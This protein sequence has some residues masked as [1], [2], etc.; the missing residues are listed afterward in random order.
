MK[1][2]IQSQKNDAANVVASSN[3]TKRKRV[4]L[5]E[6][7]GMTR[8]IL[9][10]L[11]RS[12]GL[13]VDFASN[14]S[15]ALNRLRQHPD[16]ILMELNLLGI[17]G[18]EFIREARG[19]SQFGKKP[20]YIFTCA[21]FMS[22]AARKVVTGEG[23][24]LFDKLSVLPEKVVIQIAADLMGVKLSEE[25]HEAISSDKKGFQTSLK[26]R[27]DLKK[28]LTEIHEASQVLAKSA[29]P[30]EWLVNCGELRRKV[31]GLLSFAAVARMSN[32]ARQAQ[33]LETYLNQLCNEPKLLNKS[34]L[35]TV[36][37]SVEMLDVLSRCPAEEGGEIT[38]YSAVIVDQAPASCTALND[39]FHDAGF[40]PMSFSEPDEA[41][42]HLSTHPAHLL[43]LNVRV[44]ELH[45]LDPNKIRAIP[46]HSTTP[47][48][49]V[50]SP[51]DL[52][53]PP[54][55]LPI[56]AARMDVNPVALTDLVLKALSVVQ[57]RPATSAAP[58]HTAAPASAAKKPAAEKPS[59][60]ASSPEDERKSILFVEDDPVMQ[61]V[62]KTRLEREGFRIESAED[63]LIALEMLPTV[64][65]DLVVLDLML[66]KLHG[67]E[68]LKFIRADVNLKATPVIV[69][70]NVYMEGMAVKAIKS[71][72]NMGMLKTQCTPGKLIS[73]ARE[74]LGTVPASEAP[75]LST[76]ESK[77]QAAAQ[78]VRTGDTTHEGTRLDLLK[79]APQLIAQ[80]RQDCLNFVRTSGSEV[81]QD[82]L[83]SLYRNVRFLGAR[84]GLSGFANVATAASALEALLFEI[85]FNYSPATPSA[86]QSIAQ[87]VDCLGRMFQNPSALRTSTRQKPKVLVVDDDA[88]CTTA[89]VAALKR[90]SFEAFGVQDPKFA[91]SMMQT[92]RF[93]LV[94]LDLN[95]PGMN[96]FQVCEELRKLPDYRTTPVI[97]VT[98]SGEFQDRARGI[99]AGG[100]DLITKPVSPLEL[101]LKST[102][103]LLDP[104][105]Q[106]TPPIPAVADAPAVASADSSASIQVETAVEDSGLAMAESSPEAN[107]HADIL[108]EQ[109]L[110]SRMPV[111]ASGDPDSQN[112][113]SE[114][115][116]A[117]EA[118]A[119]PTLDG[120]D[121]I[122][123]E[124]RQ[125]TEEQHEG[126][127]ETEAQPRAEGDL[128]FA[129]IPDIFQKAPSQPLPAPEA[130][131]Q[132][133]LSVPAA[134][135][136]GEEVS[137]EPPS[138]GE[139]PGFEETTDNDSE[140]AQ[141]PPPLLY[142]AAINPQEE[143]EKYKK[144]RA[145]LTARLYDA[146][147]QLDHTRSR[148]NRR[149]EAIKQLQKQL[150][151]LTAAKQELEKQSVEK[152]RIAEHSQE[153]N[154]QVRQATAEMAKR[155]KE[156]EDELSQNKAALEEAKAE[157]AKQSAERARLEEDL[158]QHLAAAASTAQRVEAT[159]RETQDR[160]ARLERDVADLRQSREELNNKF[161]QELKA[162]AES[163]KRVKELESELNQSHSALEQ[164]KAEFAKQ[165][166]ERTR[167]EQE[168]RQ[169]LAATTSATQQIEAAQNESQ[170]RCRQLEQD[171]A[172]LRQAREELTTQHA[173]ERQ[174]ATDTN[175][176]I[177]ELENELNQ[178]KAEFDRAKAEMALR[179]EERARL[180]E[181]LRKQL[182]VATTAAQ[183]AEAAQKETQ[184]RCH[185][186]GQALE[187][188]RQAREELNTKFF[189]ERR[190]ATDASKRIQE[191]EK[192]LQQNAAEAQQTKA[193][194][195]HT[196]TDL[197]RKS[198]ELS[199]QESELQQ[200]AER[201][202]AAAQQAETA[203]KQSQGRC[204]QL[205]QDL[206][207]L[208]QAREEL[209]AKYAQEQQAVAEAGNR[210]K[211]LETELSQNK[212]ALERAKTKL[213]KQTTATHHAEA[214]H[215]QNQERNRQLEADLAELRTTREQLNAKCIEEHQAAAEA[216]QRVVDLENELNQIKTALEGVKADLAKQTALTASTAQQAEAAQR[217][218]QERQRQLEQDLAALHQAREEL[219]GKYA[220]QLKAAVESARRA[221]ELETAFS[222]TNANLATVK[223]ELANQTAAAA[224]A[225]QQADTSS[226]QCQQLER[227]LTSLLQER[228]ELSGRYAQEQKAA[229]DSARRVKQLEAELSQRN[230]ELEGTKSELAKQTAQAATAVQQ[231]EAA[232]QQSQQRCEQMEQDLVALL[233][234]R[235]ELTGKYAKEQQ[236]AAEAT[237][238]VEELDAALSQSNSG[239]HRAEAELARQTAAAA[240][241]AKQ[242][243]SAQKQ[244]LERCGQLEQDLVA[245]R[246]AREELTSK[247]A[248][249]QQ[250][251][252]ESS[253]RIQR[254][255]KDLSQATEELALAQSQLEQ[256]TAERRRLE[257]E[258]RKQAEL[259]D[260]ATRH[261]EV[262]QKQNQE[263]CRLLEQDLAGLRQ[264]R[265]ELA[266]KFAREQQIVADT[267]KRTQE[268]EKE[269]AG[270]AT[271]LECTK[272]ELEK[273][274]GER[275]RLESELHQQAAAAAAATR[276]ATAIQK[277]NQDR[278]RQ[279][280]Q[281]LAG[282]A[283]GR[284]EL[285][286]KFAREQHLVAEANTRITDLEKQLVQSETTYRTEISKIE[287]RVHQGVEA[288]GRVTAELD[289]ERGD[290][291]RVEQRATALT[292]RLQELHE[293]L[294]RHLD[295]ERARDCKILNLEEQLLQ[296]KDTV[297]RLTSDLKQESTDR[298]LAEERGRAAEALNVELRQHLS[299]FEKAKQVFKRTQAELESRL[300]SSLGSLRSTETNLQ[301]GNGERQRLENALREAQNLLREQS[302]A[303]DIQQSE[304][305]AT[306]KA[307]HESQSQLRQETS[308]R[309][310][311]ASAL[312]A[313]ERTLS[314][315]TQRMEKLESQLRTV[316][317]AV[318][319]SKSTAQK[320][321]AERQ[322]LAEALDAAQRQLRDQSE[323]SDFEVSRLRSELYLE[324]VE[325]KRLETSVAQ[326]RHHAL[327]SGRAARVLRSNLRKQMQKPIE[328]MRASSRRLLQLE[329]SDEQKQLA[330]TVLQA[331][332]LIQASL[333]E[334]ETSTNGS[335]GK[336]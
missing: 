74:L 125:I 142:T 105:E 253:K 49:Q 204:E 245:L 3:G 94:L 244:A 120:A 65:P 152:A 83:N 111:E 93:D 110:Q 34:C 173:Q 15:I 314:D 227:D 184:E 200:R 108:A 72:A 182:A 146:E 25:Q 262:T 104:R 14:G 151:E 112:S 19:D 273:Q 300:E 309:Q 257:T 130:G 303:Q 136:P 166:T 79:D 238:R 8:L 133:Y 144:E 119:A 181:Y 224:T 121:T 16:A 13:D 225:S 284:E 275:A 31:Y 305:Q 321:A 256:Q 178:S 95:M 216:G 5:V 66:P 247:Y 164:A 155:I 45:G 294:S 86:L 118:A 80:L 47:V 295:A 41:I 4:L 282:L 264:A 123:E 59:T 141:T 315:Q 219:S 60:E 210:V 168:L 158:R 320:E 148:V 258:L 195:E 218:H 203:L 58:A 312:Q 115:V 193:E 75:P 145:D 226:K 160:C 139:V 213:S 70:S 325:R 248:R 20:I 269:L 326:L 246:H 9:L 52:N 221:E 206:A 48:I 308:E 7:D 335:S 288:L 122:L 156:L 21:D 293:E 296:Q 26:T 329:M 55:V 287:Q 171:L 170:A 56:S 197:A 280:E 189:K 167:L 43:V 215:K 51:S 319:E 129:E 29:K 147:V 117:A 239:L 233:Q 187:S 24:K 281:E 17:Q 40:K 243:E 97:F 77:P 39:A 231:A 292:E 270:A 127:A 23:I 328:D 211:D 67:L 336:N 183:Q 30:E 33:V 73:A 323:R 214:A 322:Q 126:Q 38:E 89:T 271:E 62:Y 169:Q 84:A 266:G 299:H 228:E 249:E 81:N 279:L 10:H 107:L 208:H 175:K 50:P 199:Q 241:A 201:A 324:G 100:N 87:A 159:Q 297:A 35:E 207:G 138:A 330:E 198:G 185:Q 57:K 27:G 82:H 268:L 202:A 61:K 134:M 301:T 131:R 333:Q 286:G 277:Q 188:L 150:D 285:K 88:V 18:A 113:E 98:V 222:Q 194:L 259:A 135:P 220:Q 272:A 42:K 37:N 212:T 234:S 236:V 90:A 191:L 327:D 302:Q 176:R 190:T 307:L 153:A 250:L 143:L 78:Q 163:G 255:E 334:T 11:L 96:G 283:E 265:E 32:L 106:R 306:T 114:A 251:A 261:A 217:Q 186:L 53:R 205:E 6:S 1:S 132:D 274:T 196:K 230:S 240:K 44:P 316:L 209:Q 242:A 63:G 91:L 68:V 331:T 92:T 2:T 260:A 157:L 22:R 313:A 69:L 177:Q 278:C 276:E 229:A 174:I 99:L 180:E 101:T 116:T 165:T 46:G 310:R 137:V 235:E 54:D 318:A 237:R 109:E 149:D 102:M 311:L 36:S 128:S 263:R 172:A 64:R 28:N 223:S 317:E 103:L 192:Q 76:A 267:Q 85:G 140:T 162:A 71:G 304:L 332:L 161:E 252:S 289:R 12:V 232:R 298:Q 154:E 124:P 291:Q 290:R 254:L 179:S